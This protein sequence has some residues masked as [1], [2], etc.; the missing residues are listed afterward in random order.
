MKKT[1]PK[2]QHRQGDVFM[3]IKSLPQNAKLVDSLSSRIVARGE[4]SDHCH[5]ITGECDIF[6]ADG[7][8]FVKAG[9]NG[10]TLQHTKESLLNF[11]KLDGQGDLHV[12]DH[13]KHVLKPSQVYSVVIQNEFNP[14][15]K[16]FDKV[17]D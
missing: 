7:R 6:E 8:M 3:M 4:W 1:I 5:V 15:R 14:Y 16:A 11:D 12:A 17:A 10:M 2:D 9:K 13:P